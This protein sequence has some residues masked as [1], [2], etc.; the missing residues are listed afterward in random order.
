MESMT[1]QEGK[2]DLHINIR[3]VLL[4]SYYAQPFIFNSRKLCLKLF[5]L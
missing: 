1:N 2:I 5:E 4:I 3:K